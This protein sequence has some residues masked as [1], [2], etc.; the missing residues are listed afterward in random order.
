MNKDEKRYY[1]IKWYGRD[2]VRAIG[3]QVLLIAYA[4]VDIMAAER[5]KTK[6]I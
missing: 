5:K 6:N 4:Y 2:M 1:K 3:N